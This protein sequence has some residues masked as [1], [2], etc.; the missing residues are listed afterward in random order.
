MLNGQEKGKKLV[1][2]TTVGAL[3]IIALKGIH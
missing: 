2:A 1:A 3:L